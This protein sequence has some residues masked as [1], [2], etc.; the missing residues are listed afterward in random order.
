M[1]AVPD[2]RTVAPVSRAKMTM[3]EMLRLVA[4]ASG[5]SVSGFAAFFFSIAG[6]SAG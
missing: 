4:E 5:L 3:R 1:G 2:K 6:A